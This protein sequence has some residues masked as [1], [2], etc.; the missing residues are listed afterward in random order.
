MGKINDSIIAN[1][2]V[3]GEKE[4]K[5]IRKNYDIGR[6]LT[7]G[8]NPMSLFKI[9]LPDKSSNT[10]VFYLNINDTIYFR[11]D[12]FDRILKEYEELKKKDEEKT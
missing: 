3:C 6:Q 9:Y 1:T 10:V 12:D 8:L 7:N 4:F 11:R 5:E 2:I